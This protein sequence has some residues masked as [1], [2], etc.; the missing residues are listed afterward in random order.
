MRSLAHDR[1]ASVAEYAGL[2]VIAALILGGLYATGIPAKVTHG[3]SRA[4]CRIQTGTR[5]SCGDRPA[6]RA[7]PAGHRTTDGRP[8]T[9]PARRGDTGCHGVWGCVGS[10]LKSAGG[11]AAD[12]AGSMGSGLAHAAAHPLDTV[13]NVG[14]S[15]WNTMG[16]N[17]YANGIRACGVNG[18]E[19]DCLKMAISIA[20]PTMGLMGGVP[21]SKTT[22]DSARKGDYAGAAGRAGVEIGANFIPVPGVKALGKAAKAARAAKNADRAGEGVPK[23]SRWRGLDQWR[24]GSVYYGSEAAYKKWLR[25]S[26]GPQSARLSDAEQ[27]ALWNYRHDPDYRIINGALRGERKATPQADEDIR[28]LDSAMRKSRVP[29]DVITTRLVG[30]DAFTRPPAQLRGTVQKDPGFMSVNAAPNSPIRPVPMKHMTNR[31]A[32]PVELHLRVP[33]GTPAAYP[34]GI[35]KGQYSGKPSDDPEIVLNRGTQYRIDHAE[36]IDGKWHLYGTVVR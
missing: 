17:R 33:K 3:T 23:T 35:K 15:L 2:I 13:E 36:K 25:E 20:N 29:D 19:Y 30:D 28:G 5:A 12:A 22:Y 27:R 32:K 26:M 9:G 6:I 7:A 14:S 24:K 4:L 21:V 8:G 34:G 18:S 16:P 31:G 1:G 11:G 10:A